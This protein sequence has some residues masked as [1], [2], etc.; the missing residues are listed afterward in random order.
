V[1]AAVAL[2]ATLVIGGHNVI[3]I[4]GGCILVGAV[5]LAKSQWCADALSAIKMSMVTLAWQ[6]WGAGTRKQ[7]P[8]VAGRSHR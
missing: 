3:D 1:F 6:T 8:I 4:I 2:A 5:V 7:S